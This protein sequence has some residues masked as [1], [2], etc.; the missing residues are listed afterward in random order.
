MTR[1]VGDLPNLLSRVITDGWFD[2]VTAL[3]EE[4]RAMAMR[5]YDAFVSNF[6][7]PTHGWRG[8]VASTRCANGW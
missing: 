2:E 1:K 5:E 6:F 7:R 4:T 3:V 8:A